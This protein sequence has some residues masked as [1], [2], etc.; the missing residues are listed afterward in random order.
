VLISAIEEDNIITILLDEFMDLTRLQMDAAANNAFFINLEFVLP[1]LE[2][3][4]LTP[5]LYAHSRKVIPTAVAPF[6]NDI[7][8]SCEF[9]RGL[10]VSFQIIHI[11]TDRAIDAMGRN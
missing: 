6:K 9:F 10:D 4:E 5:S 3:D 11:T 1:I 7:L 2:A 8:K